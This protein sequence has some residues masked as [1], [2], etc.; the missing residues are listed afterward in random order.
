MHHHGR[1]Q[2]VGGIR[3]IPRSYVCSR[4]RNTRA[5]RYLRIFGE[6]GAMIPLVPDKNGSLQVICMSQ[7]PPTGRRNNMQT[8][9]GQNVW[10]GTLT[11]FLY[12]ASLIFDDGVAMPPSTPRIVSSERQLSALEDAWRPDVLDISH[13]GLRTKSNRERQVRFEWGQDVGSRGRTD[14][15]V[16]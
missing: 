5:R 11:Y 1:R 8:V 15:Y 4:C 10:E 14:E 6:P 13:L 16:R 12:S 7:T 2:V 3:V 9:R